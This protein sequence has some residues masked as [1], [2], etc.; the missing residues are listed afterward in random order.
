[1]EIKEATPD[2][3][4]FITNIFEEYRQFYRQKP[5]PESSIFLKSR[6]A[7]NES[8]FFYVKEKNDIIGFVQLY[9]SFSSCAL[10]KIYILNDL[11]V[12]KEF[13]RK[14]IAWQLLEHV[15]AWTKKNGASEIHLATAIPN[16]EAQGLY[17]KFGFKKDNDFFYFNLKI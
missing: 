8:K 14:K 6:I 2:D 7:N 3:V 15:A 5:S 10:S 16:T 12:L 1:M 4:N 17:K 13:R 9:P 11:Y